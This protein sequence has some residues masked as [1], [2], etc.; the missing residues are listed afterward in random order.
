MSAAEEKP[1]LVE[2][3]MTDQ[4]FLELLLGTDRQLIGSEGLELELSEDSV[5]P[6]INFV[7]CDVKIKNEMASKDW[8]GTGGMKITIVVKPLSSESEISL[9]PPKR[10]GAETKKLGQV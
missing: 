3:I 5:L 4:D 6:M 1:G 8:R 9:T 7:M 2:E 10:L